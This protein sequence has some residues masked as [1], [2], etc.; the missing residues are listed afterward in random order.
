VVRLEGRLFCG[1]MWIPERLRT[2]EDVIQLTVEWP[3]TSM[4]K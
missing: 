2:N 4:V 1:V 3:A